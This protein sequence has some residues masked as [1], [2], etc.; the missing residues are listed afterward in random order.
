MSE[1]TSTKLSE[2]MCKTYAPAGSFP[3]SVRCCKCP[4]LMAPHSDWDL[5]QC[6]KHGNRFI[7]YLEWQCWACYAW[8]DGD[9][10]LCTD[11]NYPY[12]P[13]CVTE[14]RE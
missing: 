3:S 12:G 9:W 7:E 10:E 6:P 4:D 14:W 5:E 11:C 13:E 1:K 2:Q 8:Q